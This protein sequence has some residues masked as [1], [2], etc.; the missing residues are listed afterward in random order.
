MEAEWWRIKA[1]YRNQLFYCKLH[2]IWICYLSTN[3]CNMQQIAIIVDSNHIRSWNI[4]QQTQCKHSEN[5]SALFTA[6]IYVFCLRKRKLAYAF[7]YVLTVR[8]PFEDRSRRKRADMN[9]CAPL[10]TPYYKCESQQ[11]NI[12]HISKMKSFWNGLNCMTSKSYDW[13]QNETT[14][15][16]LNWEAVPQWSA[17]TIPAYFMHGLVLFRTSSGLAWLIITGLKSS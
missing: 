4:V 5:D 16:A 9:H 7:W 12:N 6:A 15:S 14:I 2:W 13:H 17:N 8:R 3:T 10:Q 1:R 11:L